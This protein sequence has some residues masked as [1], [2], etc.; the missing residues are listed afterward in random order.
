MHDLRA[1]VV[2]ASIT[3][4][5]KAGGNII[6]GYLSQGETVEVT[7]DKDGPPRH[8]LTWWPI[9]TSRGSVFGWVAEKDGGGTRLVR[10]EEVPHKG[11]PV[12]PPRVDPPLPDWRP[13]PRRLPDPPRGKPATPWGL[14][15]WVSAAAILVVIALSFLV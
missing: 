3:V 14:V 6:V 2:A 10:I 7:G 4:H 1:V 15:A 11:P 5:E 8:K 9:K 12:D 13:P